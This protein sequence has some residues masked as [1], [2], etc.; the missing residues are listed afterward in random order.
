MRFQPKY[1]KTSSPT[2]THSC[3]KWSTGG[4]NRSSEEGAT[5]KYSTPYDLAAPR[6]Y[7]CQPQVSICELYENEGSAEAR[8]TVSD[9]G[10]WGLRS[11]QENLGLVAA[12][13]APMQGIIVSCPELHGYSRALQ[14]TE[15]AATGDGRPTSIGDESG[16]QGG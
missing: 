1:A 15:E 5:E 9:E 6:R 12:A 14:A 8:R 13:C 10:S 3:F 16:L 11:L 7:L 2:E 4:A